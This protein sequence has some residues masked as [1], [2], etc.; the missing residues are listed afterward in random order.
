MQIKKPIVFFDLET[1]GTDTLND[2]IVQIAI[3]KLA[4]D[5]TREEKERLINPTIPIPPVV[6][7]V[8]GVSDEMV[9]DAPT[10][11]QVAK[12]LFEF[13]KG[14]DLAGYNHL[15]FDMPLLI[16]EF[17]RAGVVFPEPDVQYIDVM[18]IYYHF[19]PRTLSAAYQLYCQKELENAHNAMADTQATLEIFESQLTTHFDE[20]PSIN[21]IHNLCFSSRHVDFSRRLA[22]DKEGEIVFAFGK[23]KGERVRDNRGYAEWMLKGGFPADTKRVLQELLQS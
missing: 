19:H 13:I 7:K 12:S 16:E 2:R 15:N 1:T 10:F 5:G 22:R 3:I 11:H 6:T 14:C 8:H 4:A 17:A 20:E 18:K 9:K 23:H 21:E